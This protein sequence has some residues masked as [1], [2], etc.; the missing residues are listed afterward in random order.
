MN[1]Y[2]IKREGASQATNRICPK[3]LKRL[4]KSKDL[5]RNYIC[6]WQ[7]G[8]AFE[9][10]SC[11]GS[12]RVVNLINRTCSCGRWQLNGISCPHACVAIFTDQCN[13]EDFVHTCYWYDTYKKAYA[14]SIHPMS[15]PDEW[16]K[17]TLNTILP[18]LVRTQPGRPKKARRKEIDEP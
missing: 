18:P 5:Q 15:G 9:V 7:D 17:V 1:R 16:P 3:I 13:P 12:E 11:Y 2:H 6:E 8:A 14:P 4:E 10:D